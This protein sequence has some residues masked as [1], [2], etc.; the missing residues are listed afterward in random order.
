MHVRDSASAL[1]AAVLLGTGCNE[2]IYTLGRLPADVEKRNSC[3]ETED[4]STECV[5]KSSGGRANT[6]GAGTIGSGGRINGSGGVLLDAHAGV[7]GSTNGGA[8]MIDASSGCPN[9]SRPAVR[10]ALNLY[11][12]VDKS[13]SVVLQPA[14][15]SLTLAINEFVDDP[16]NEGLGLGIGYYGSSCNGGD[17]ALPEVRVAPLPGVAQAIKGSYPVPLSGKAVTPALSGSFAYMRVLAQTEPDRDVAVALVTDTIVDPICGSTQTNAA[18]AAAGALAESPSIPT[19]VIGLGA[20]PTL[21][22]PVNL[23]DPAPLD[24][25]AAAGGTGEV[26]RIEVNLSTNTA[27]TAAL[28]DVVN[29][30]TPCAFEVPDDIEPSTAVLESHP[31]SLPA[32][33]WSHVA[34]SGACGTDHGV[35]IRPSSPRVLELCPASCNYLRS[36][37]AGTVIVRTDCR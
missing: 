21:L 24:P 10:R 33:T 11:L 6:G 37:A 1:I 31:T 17:Y 12:I 25:V 26:R 16:K 19:Y 3:R 5:T 4:A 29:A 23:I 9:D 18:L 8:P 36:G 15:N 7:G 27:L 35:Y 13:L 30:A 28:N 22:D 32:N 20:G 14:W 2:A 34:N